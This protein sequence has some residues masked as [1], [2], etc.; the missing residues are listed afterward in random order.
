VMEPPGIDGVKSVEI[1]WAEL[2]GNKA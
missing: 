1:S 2:P